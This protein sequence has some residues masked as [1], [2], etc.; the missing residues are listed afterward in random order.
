[1]LMS[2]QNRIQSMPISR[3]VNY[4][5]GNVNFKGN[6]EIDLVKRCVDSNNFYKLTETIKQKAT[7]G[8][9]KVD[10]VEEIINA[11][12]NAFEQIIRNKDS[13]IDSQNQRLNELF[14]NNRQSNAEI[15]ELN[16]EI[17]RLKATLIDPK[18]IF[19]VNQ[20]QLPKPQ[21]ITKVID[22]LVKNRKEYLDALEDDLFNG[23]VDKNGN[24]TFSPKVKEF[25]TNLHIL[26]KAYKKGFFKINDLNNKCNE[27]FNQYNYQGSNNDI[28][29]VGNSLIPRSRLL[30]EL[31]PT[32]LKYSKNNTIFKKK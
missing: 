30:G 31:I 11:T 18:T 27:F 8:R 24:P 1:M 21:E 23:K 16:E 25:A 15:K 14:D 29:S 19:D 32:V 4:N 10:F 2:V 6:N 12:K 5:S 26:H 17:K 28:Y 13:V 22:T 9:I 7:L 3:T 20:V